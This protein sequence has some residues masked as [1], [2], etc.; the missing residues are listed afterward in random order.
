MALVDIV[1]KRCD[2]CGKQ[3]ARTKAMDMTSVD[4]TYESMK[5]DIVLCPE[6]VEKIRI[7]LYVSNIE[8]EVKKGYGGFITNFITKRLVEYINTVRSEVVIL[9]KQTNSQKLKKELLEIITKA[10]KIS[11][12]YKSYIDVLYTARDI[13]ESKANTLPQNTIHIGIS[14]YAADEKFLYCMPYGKP[15]C[16]SRE[17]ESI[18]GYQER[19]DTID[20]LVNNVINCDE[21]IKKIRI[22]D[23]EY[24]QEKGEVNYSTEISGGGGGRINVS[25][26]VIGG[27]TF[28]I[29]GAVI[30]SRAGKAAKN[31]EIQSETIK[32]DNRSV[33]LRYIDTEGKINDE[34]YS[35]E[36]YDVFNQLIPNKEYA[37]VQIH[38]S[39]NN[40]DTGNVKPTVGGIPVEELKQLKELMDME[41]ITK[42]EFE[43]KK[44]I[45]LGL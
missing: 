45:L 2:L 31:Q 20:T 36:Y 44:R 19:L 25:G 7:V 6:C 27:L 34:V 21:I 12:K 38:G 43:A 18:S 26:A 24:F 5:N 28:G 17:L 32:H 30:A 37:Y 41:V 13:I 4:Y 22:D 16:N 23:I 9:Q 29:A 33:V 3:I 40:T 35:F 8:K 42:E 15:I 39:K 14:S 10:D 1:R 11:N